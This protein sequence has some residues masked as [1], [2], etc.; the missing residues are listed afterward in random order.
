VIDPK[1]I[2]KMQQIAE[3]VRAALPGFRGCVEFHMPSDPGRKVLV[4]LK[5]Y[6]V[7]GAKK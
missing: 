4:D 1:V 3:Q 7:T 6:D 5:L 2:A